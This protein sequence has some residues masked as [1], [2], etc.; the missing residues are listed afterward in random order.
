[1]TSSDEQILFSMKSEK[2]FSLPSSFFHYGIRGVI[3]H[4]NHSVLLVATLVG[5]SWAD[6]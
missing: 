1:M 2:P 6:N 3:R 4:C 5:L